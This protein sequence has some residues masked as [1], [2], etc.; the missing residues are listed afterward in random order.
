MT[1]ITPE[2]AYDTYVRLRC[3]IIVATGRTEG[4]IKVDGGARMGQVILDRAVS[5]M[6]GYEARALEE[7]EN[8]LAVAAK[9]ELARR[10]P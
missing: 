4:Q 6:T 2:V 5:L 8:P 1:N 10:E 9:D 3:A 7:F